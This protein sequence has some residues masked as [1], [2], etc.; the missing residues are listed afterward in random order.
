MVSVLE[1]CWLVKSSH[2]I[3]LELFLE[4]PTEI[5]KKVG[6]DGAS[7]VKRKEISGY[8]KLEA[9]FMRLLFWTESSQLT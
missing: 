1:S 6:S 4:Q 9:R 8:L 5:V 3:E 7:A 2:G